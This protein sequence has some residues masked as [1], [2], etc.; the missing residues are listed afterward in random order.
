M[1]EPTFLT[2]VAEKCA[3]VEEVPAIAV[4]RLVA[5]SSVGV[6]DGTEP[7]TTTLVLGAV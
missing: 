2:P 4:Y 7:L 6:I 5:R 3:T 1:L